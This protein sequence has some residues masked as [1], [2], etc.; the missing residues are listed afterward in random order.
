M[1]SL[2][3]PFFV[4][5]SLQLEQVSEMGV[6]IKPP[7]CDLFIYIILTNSWTAALEREDDHFFHADEALHLVILAKDCFFFQTLPNVPLMKTAQ[8]SIQAFFFAMIIII[9]QGIEVE[10]AA[11][12]SGMA[13]S[14]CTCRGCKV[15]CS[16]A[17]SRSDLGRGCGAAGCCLP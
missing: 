8:W 9:W 11:C 5:C 13:E 2:P 10:A 6:S 12:M 7:K 1:W 17:E 4:T 3:L 14:P 15:S 16:T